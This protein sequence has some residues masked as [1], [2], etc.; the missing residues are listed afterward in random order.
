MRRLGLATAMLACSLARGAAAEPAASPA[1]HGPPAHEGPW[2][3]V[4]S[5]GEGH[6]A[7]HQLT[8]QGNA[9]HGES[10][11][12]AAGAH[13]SAEHGAHGGHAPS[14]RDI[15]WFYGMIAEKEHVEP[16]LLWRPTG[17][18]APLGA[19]ILNTAIVFYLL[20]RYGKK[21]LYAALAKRKS[22]LLRGI[23]EA[24][25]MRD[26]AQTRW[27][28]YEQKLA[29]IDQQ[30]ERMRQELRESALAER[31]RVLSEARAK[32]ERLVREAHVTVEHELKAAHD[33]LVAESVRQGVSQAR[34]LMVT[35]ISAADQHRFLDEYLGSVAQA[36]TGGP[37]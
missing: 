24:A 3:Q 16:S 5:L 29:H 13:Q 27:D 17:M 1:G 26:Q 23:E 10:N 15:N 12:E 22:G 36:R 37:S 25:E 9:A 30:I 34:Q 35:Q 21:P 6:P 7:G 28:E 32:G 19:L 8:G 4:P 2:V 33:Q 11:S 14:W 31:E 18:P 20:G